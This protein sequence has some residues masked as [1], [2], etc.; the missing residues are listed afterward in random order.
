MPCTRW[1]ISRGKNL[2]LPKYKAR[3]TNLITVVRSARNHNIFRIP[4]LLFQPHCY[5]L[6]GFQSHFWSQEQKMVCRIP[7]QHSADNAWCF[8]LGLVSPCFSG[9]L[10]PQ[11]LRVTATPAP[12]RCVTNPA[13]GSTNAPWPVPGFEVTLQS[14]PQECKHPLPVRFQT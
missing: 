5:S 9:K 14:C 1:K 11:T 8:N 12:P 4:S 3:G 10:V 13:C 2:T 6:T 7:V